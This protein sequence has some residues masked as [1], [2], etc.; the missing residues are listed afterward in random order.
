MLTAVRFSGLPARLALAVTTASLTPLAQ[1]AFIED[2][3]ATLQARNIYFNRDFREDAGQSKREEWM[4]GFILDVRSGFTD[5]SVGFGLD[6]LGMLGV[7]LDSGRGRS[8]TDLLPVHDDGGTPDDFSR[9][10]LTAKARFAETELRYGTHIPEMPVAMA[11]DSR[12]LPQVFEGAS[13]V[14]QDVEG[15]TLT[16]GRLDQVTDRASTGGQD[17]Q[18]NNKNNRFASA[19]EADHLSFAGADYA[20]AENLSGRYYFA[21]LDDV[22]RQHFFGLLAV[23]P[24]GEHSALSA[25][26][27]LMVSDDSGAANAGRIDNQAWNGMLGYRLGGHKV[28]VAYQRMSGDTGYAY[29]D[30]S[31]PFLVNFVQIND[32][33]NADERSWQVRYDYNF[34]AIGIPGLTFLTR[35][36]SGDDARIAGSDARGSE[37]ERDLELK[38]VVQSGPLKNVALRMRNAMFRSDFARDADENRLIVSYS[39]PIW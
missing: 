12:T 33:A 4:Q 31:D 15:L 25:D 18:L 36:V 38:Y 21:E 30:G 22:Y 35:Y 32:F 14:S 1:A 39:L 6:A 29:L 37:W 19:A 2:S 26:L 17:L 7:K 11:S 16:G 24:L 8:G 10:G 3:S 9:L 27:R 34:A 5:G 13:L 20:F 23:R 28:S